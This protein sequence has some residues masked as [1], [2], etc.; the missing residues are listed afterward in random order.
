VVK[1]FSVLE[2]VVGQ[3]YGNAGCQEG[4]K[5]EEIIKSFKS[6]ISTTKSRLKIVLF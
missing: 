4:G 2:A 1:A 3:L 6:Q 5:V